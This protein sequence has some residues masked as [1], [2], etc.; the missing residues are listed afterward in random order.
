MLKPIVSP[1]PTIPPTIEW[2]VEMGSPN[3]DAIKSQIP[4][5]NNADIIIRTKS[6]GF[7][8]LSGNTMI[9]SRIVLVTSPPAKIAPLSSKMAAITRACFMV[10]VFAPTLVPKLLATSLP[11]MLNAINIPKALAM[12]KIKK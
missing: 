7:M 8:P 12:Q 3:L 10:S 2:V 9:P 11:P 1:A 5:L 6:M 4:E